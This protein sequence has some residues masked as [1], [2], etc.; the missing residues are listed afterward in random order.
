MKKY[1]SVNSECNKR[2][3]ILMLCERRSERHTYDVDHIGSILCCLTLN[4]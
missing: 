3:Y 2:M 4:E 1:I